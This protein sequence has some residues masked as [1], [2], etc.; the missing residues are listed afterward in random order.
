MFSS[1]VDQIYSEQQTPI[2]V[3]HSEQITLL[4]YTNFRYK[5]PSDTATNGG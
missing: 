4:S 5:T 3:K 2:N 1:A